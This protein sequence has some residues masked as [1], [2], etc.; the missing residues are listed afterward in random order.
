MTN[1]ISKISF[2]FI[3]IL[4]IL[5]LNAQVTIGSG[6][7]PNKGSLLDLKETNN[8][9]V[10]SLRGL[11]MPRVSLSDR[12]NLYPIFTSDGAGGY[13]GVSKTEEDISHR[14]LSVYA[15]FEFGDPINCPGLYV[16]DGGSWNPLMSDGNKTQET[17]THL[18]DR[19][20]NKYTIA[21]FGSAGIWMTQNLRVTETPCG[22]PLTRSSVSSLKIKHY[23]FPNK[24]SSASEGYGLLYN[25][26]AATNGVKD[27]TTPNQG[28]STM[29][30]GT[31]NNSSAVEE[32]GVQGIC[33]YGWH[34][35]SDKEWNDLEKVISEN[36]T[37]Y[38]TNTIIAAWSPSWC[39]TIGDYRGT[40]HG[41]NMKSPIAVNSAFPN[42]G[43]LSNT[44]G[45]GFNAY[46]VGYT[47][48]NSAVSYGS[49]GFFWSSSSTGTGNA[50]SRIFV[51]ASA[52][53]YPGVS[54]TS[55]PAERLY[56]IR[57]KKND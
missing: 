28:E 13:Q 26:L 6:S 10:N 47:Y 33:P 11:Q 2:L 14:G 19:Q 52:I 51:A 36:P 55:N 16:W 32:R 12:N 5:P 27:S 56:S 30:A 44:D 29:V 40:Q 24:D 48:N 3:Y 39:L 18:Y 7:Q 54:R 4:F 45:N 1:A 38:S 42:T 20:G 31:A 8:M 50:W 21:A 46:M 35:P 37:L 57:C 49:Y 9:G 41:K 43:G 15:P 17:S 34:L 53:N 22:K 23:D 25:W